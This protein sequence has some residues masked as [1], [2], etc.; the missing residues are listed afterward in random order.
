KSDNIYNP[1]K[2]PLFYPSL[3]TR[4]KPPGRAP[5]RKSNGCTLR[6]MYART[7]KVDVVIGGIRRPCPLEWLDSFCMRNFTGQAEFDDTLPIGEGQI[8]AGLRISPSRLAD[9]L[10]NWL[11]QR[12]KVNAQAVKVEIKLMPKS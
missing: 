3:R 7:M 4:C 12:G 10:S 2:W 5:N 1:F 6:L 11:T 8:E 9:A